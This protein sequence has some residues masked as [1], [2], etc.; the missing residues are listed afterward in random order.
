VRLA[1][2]LHLVPR[3]SSASTPLYAFV[4]CTGTYRYLIYKKL[5]QKPVACV[6]YER[7]HGSYVYVPCVIVKG[8]TRFWRILWLRSKPCFRRTT[9]IWLHAVLCMCMGV[10]YLRGWEGFKWYTLYIWY[11]NGIHYIY[12]IYY[13][14]DT[15]YKTF[16]TLI[17]PTSW[18]L[19]IEGNLS[20]RSWGAVLIAVL[21]FL[22]VWRKYRRPAQFVKAQP[23]QYNHCTGVV[24]VL[25]PKC[26]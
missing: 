6:K 13:V 8:H 21:T 5:T 17:L 18:R 16:Y 11:I 15:Q 3:L 24:A 23:W 25:V 20:T 19:H 12:R 1:P 14:Y 10:F 2:S 7:T 9:R 4:A 26:G 22:P